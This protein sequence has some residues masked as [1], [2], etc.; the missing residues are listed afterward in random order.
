MPSDVDPS[1]L[2]ERLP[3]GWSEVQHEG[4]RF[5]VTRSIHAGGRSESVYAEEL[6]GPGVVS[7]NLYRVGDRAQLRPC[8]MPAD[9]VLDF[10]SR[11]RVVPRGSRPAG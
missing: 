1:T 11:L 2:F 6:G 9:I 4:R 7:A 3:V 8:E 10:L 5:G